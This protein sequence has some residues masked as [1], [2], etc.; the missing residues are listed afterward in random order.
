MLAKLRMSK[1][2]RTRS[3]KKSPAIQVTASNRMIDKLY[4]FL[5]SLCYNIRKIA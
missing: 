4:Q 2:G 3:R 1:E 5:I